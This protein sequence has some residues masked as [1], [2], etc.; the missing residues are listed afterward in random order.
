MKNKKRN[1]HSAKKRKA[2]KVKHVYVNQKK[3]LNTISS[4]V[5]SSD[6]GDSERKQEPKTQQNR[7][8]NVLSPIQ[9][10][11]AITPP[12]PPPPSSTSKSEE[13][14]SNNLPIWGFRKQIIEYVRQNSVVLI[15]AETGSGKTTQVA[16]FLHECGFTSKKSSRMYTDEKAENRNPISSTSSLSTAAI[17]ATTTTTTGRNPKN[18]YFLGR[19][20]AITQPRR[21]AAITVAKRVAEEMGCDIGT[22]VGYRVRFQDCSDFQGTNTTR[23]LY[24]TDGMLLREAMMD[25]LLARYAVVIL[26]EGQQ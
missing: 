18:C 19:T 21:V 14:S 8:R 17:A 7:D 2:K 25:P 5:V 6:K 13:L 10:T 12:P 23:I 15:T 22:M 26:D 24:V 1:K 4:M 11:K 9:A 20:I 3:T 16:K